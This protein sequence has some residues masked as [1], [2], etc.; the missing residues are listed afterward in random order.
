MGQAY[1]VSCVARP[2]VAKVLKSVSD[3]WCLRLVDGLPA[4]PDE[5]VPEEFN[6]IRLGLGGNMVTVKAVASGLSL[7]TWSGI[8]TEFHDAVLRLAE[9]LAKEANGRVEMGSP[10]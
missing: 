6:E 1:H 9:A 7:V 4:F 3:A 5:A 10:H 2:S 8:S